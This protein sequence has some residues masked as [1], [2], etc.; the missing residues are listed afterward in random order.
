MDFGAIVVGAGHNGL[1]CA[2]Y[3][4]KSGIK[5]LVIEARQNVGGCA[6]TEDFN[7]ALV[8]ICNCDHAMVR[9]LPIAEEL[10]LEQF[11]LRYL[12]VDPSYLH[13]QHDKSP[14]WFLFN[15]VERTLASLQFSYPTEVDNYRRYLKAAMPVAKMVIEIAQNIPTPGAVTKTVLRNQRAAAKAIP[16]LLQWSKRSVGD[17][18]RSFFTAEQLRGPL[19]TTGPSVWGVSPETPGTG[20]GA[21]GFAFRHS[22]QIGRP[23]GGSGGLTQAILASF[24]ASGGTVRTG[25]RVEKILCEGDHVR[26]VKLTTGEVL[27]APIV[28]AAGNPRSALVDWLTDPPASAHDL[29]KRYQSMHPHDGY[30]SKIDAVLDAKYSIPMVNDSMRAALGLSMTDVLTP[31]MVVSK[32]LAELSADHEAKTKG[33][34]ADRPQFL[35]QLP[36]ILDHSV[37]SQLASNE[38]VFSLEVL[39]TPYQLQGGWQNSPEPLRWLSRVSDLVEMPDSRPLSEHIV[40]WR[41]MS[42][43]EYER[44]LSMTRGH[45]PSFAGTPITALLG[46]NRE[47]SRYET[48]IHGLFLTG[49]ATFPGAGIWGAPGRNAASAI[50]S[51]DRR[52]R[53]SQSR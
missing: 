19:A 46:R 45:A 48:P 1:L 11:G 30:E 16:T 2:A 10:A 50:L 6:A 15:N 44:E 5:T 37:S 41:L 18:I 27:E 53:R 23:V 17:V 38:Q 7:G 40:S 39:W 9:T 49:A 4:A 25:E 28:V 22:V 36:S 33:M 29:I 47:Q 14:G 20:L 43:I 13:V 21:L 26:G 24:I 42:P 52:V 3:L 51:S 34:I 31:S 35:V 32:P 8:N 12:D